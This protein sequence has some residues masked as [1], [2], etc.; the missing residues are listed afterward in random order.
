MAKVR[1]HPLEGA[2][3]TLVGPQ[4]ELQG[5]L[6]FSGGLVVEGRVSGR[7]IAEAGKAAVLTVAAQGR[8]EGEVHAPV[9]I[10]RG[11]VQGDVH[12]SE[13]V[14]LMEGA[15]IEGDVHYRVIEVGAGARLEGR[16]V[17][18][19]APVPARGSRLHLAAEDGRIT[20][21]RLAIG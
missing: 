18:V 8:I 19:P 15:S 5:E 13:C 14:A 9:V 1:P 16:L 17:H 4:V 7:V 12:A 2:I 11:A 6:R 10:V 21:E 20:A 3:D